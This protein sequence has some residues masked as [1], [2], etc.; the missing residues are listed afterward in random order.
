MKPLELKKT[1]RQIFLYVPNLIGYTRII[2]GLISICIAFDCPTL[3]IVFYSISHLLDAA[4][5]YAARYLDQCSNFGAVLDMITDRF[6]TAS[7]VLIL[8]HLYPSFLVPFAY[9]NILDFVSHWLR[10]Y[11]AAGEHHKKENLNHHFLLNLY[12][13]N[14]NVLGMVC[15]FNE[16]FYIFLYVAKF[17]P[18]PELFSVMNYSL[19]LSVAFALLCFPVFFFKQYVN[20]LQL[21]NACYDIV[22]KDCTAAVKKTS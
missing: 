15:L 21:V 22:K 20:V 4:D 14:R 10:M 13:T 8:S 16:F 18:G 7:L 2:L 9:L 5:G 3:F 19:N 17:F 6:C 1:P 12:Y 11:S